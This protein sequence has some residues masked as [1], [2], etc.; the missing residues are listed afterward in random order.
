LPFACV[1]GLFSSLTTTK[2]V[3]RR[4]VWI[5]SAVQF[6]FIVLFTHLFYRYVRSSMWPPKHQSHL[7]KHAYLMNQVRMQAVIAII[8]STFAGFSMAIC[9]N[10]VLLQILRWRARHVAS[11]TTTTTGEGGHGSREPPAADLEI[12]LPPS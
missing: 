5:Y 2:M 7:I 11:P 10:S 1:L 9:T 4:Y 3:S 6:L 12:A 8:L